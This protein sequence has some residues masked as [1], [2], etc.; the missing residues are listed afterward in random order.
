MLEGAKRDIAVHKVCS[1]VSRNMGSERQR[2]GVEGERKREGERGG[3]V[4]GIQGK[5]G[6]R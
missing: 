3:D 5:Q 4:I 6:V 2:G 1:L